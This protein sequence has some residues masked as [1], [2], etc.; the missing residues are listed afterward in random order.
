MVDINIHVNSNIIEYVE[1]I[2]LVLEH[3]IVKTIKEQTYSEL[4]LDKSTLN[5]PANVLGD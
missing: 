4:N 2:H 5:I 1:D 3:I